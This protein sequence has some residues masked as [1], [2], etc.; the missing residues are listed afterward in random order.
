MTSVILVILILLQLF[1]FYLIALLYAKFSSLKDIEKKHEQVLAEMDDSFGAY[2]AE[3]IDENNRLIQELN[4]S[5]RTIATTSHEYAKNENSKKEFRVSNE[6]PK[7][8]ISKQLAANSYLKT[9]ATTEIKEPVTIKEKVL[10]YADEGKS[11]DEIAKLLQIGKT[12]VEL[13]LKFKDK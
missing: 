12:E 9:A 3:I 10:F 1:S 2:I 4:S 5:E 11:K 7:S 6:I 13:F 8:Y